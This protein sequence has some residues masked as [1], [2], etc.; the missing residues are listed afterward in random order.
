VVV[1]VDFGDRD[2]VFGEFKGGGEFFVDRGEGF[3][4]AAPGGEEFD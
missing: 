4:V 2:F 3:T 1:G